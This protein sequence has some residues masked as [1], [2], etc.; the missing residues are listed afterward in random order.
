VM[1]DASHQLRFDA[2]TE[3]RLLF[4]NTL[5][6]RLRNIVAAAAR[7]DMYH[8]TLCIFVTDDFLADCTVRRW[9]D[10]AICL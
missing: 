6:V 9:H 4:V 10:N 5:V 3:Y 7:L 8:W 2:A 1:E